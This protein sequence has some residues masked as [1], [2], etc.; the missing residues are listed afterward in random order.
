MHRQIV[1]LSNNG[2]I[3]GHSDLFTLSFL[4]APLIRLV[5]VRSIINEFLNVS[6]FL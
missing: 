6:L 1:E 4:D 3:K 2:C 5:S